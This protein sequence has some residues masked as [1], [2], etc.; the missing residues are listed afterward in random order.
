MNDDTQPRPPQGLKAELS[1]ELPPEFQEDL[2][3]PEAGWSRQDRSYDEEYTQ[4]SGPGCFAWVFVILFVGLIGILVVVMAGA[5]GWTEGRR[6]ADR[7]VQATSMAFIGRQFT[8]IETNVADFNSAQLATRIAFLATQT[9]GIPQ[10]ADYQQTAIA[11]DLHLTAT[12]E[13]IINEQLDLIGQALEAGDIAQFEQRVGFLATQ[14]PAIPQVPD[15]YVTATAWAQQP[16]ATPEPETPAPEETAVDDPLTTEETPASNSTGGTVGDINLDELLARAQ[17]EISFNQLD[18]A[19]RTLDLII[20]LDET[21]QSQTVRR[22]MFDA[23]VQQATV[24]YQVTLVNNPRQT[25]TLAEAVRLTDQ[26]E[27]YGT[28]AQLGDLVY[29]RDLANLYLN[30]ISAMETAD[31][32]IAIQRL[33]RIRSFQSEYKGVSISRLIFNQYV[34]YG[35]AFANYDRDFCRAAEQYR[36]AL[37]IFA[38]DSVSGKRNNAVNQCQ[39]QQEAQQA[40][41]QDGIPPTNEEGV[42]PIGVPGS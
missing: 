15:L 3:L 27:R 22:M 37:T 4:Q 24:A 14:T 7:N 2:S 28:T 12:Q 11:V 19:T 34:G 40:P 16:T 23:L 25:G 26:A 30:A 20:R 38:D 6:V 10:V 39:A 13:A 31:F 9:P 42:A 36:I 5:A 8:A 33:E 18:E 21:Y 35:D 41:P 29:E 32:S 1:Q 17:Q